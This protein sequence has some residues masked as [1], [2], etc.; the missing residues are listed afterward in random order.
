[1][2]MMMNPWNTNCSLENRML[3][4]SRNQPPGKSNRALLLTAFILAALTLPACHR[5]SKAPT[6]GAKRYPFTGRVISIDAKDQSALINGDNI[7]GFMD[8]MAMS[9]KIKPPSDLDKLAAGDSISAEVVV[10]EEEE[11][12]GTSPDYWLENVKVTA[13]AKAKE[14]SATTQ[15][16]PAPGDVVPD[17]S[18]TNQNGRTVSLKQYH[19]KVLLVTFIYT[20]CPFQDFC[21]RMSSNFAQIYNQL[22]TDKTLGARARLLS[23]SFDPEH[24]KPKVLREYAYSVAH[25]HDPKLFREWGFAT[26]RPSDLP[27]IAD[28]FGVIYKTENGRITHNLSTTVIGPDGKIVSWYHGGDWQPSDLIKDATAAMN[29][30]SSNASSKSS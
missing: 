4:S 3:S 21:P 29:R 27:K 30:Q 13:H 15:R 19:G 11:K 5:S 25:T 16:I 17:F 28:F 23:V 9:Y 22:M 12:T 7:P 10:T 2:M 20:R 14:N 24:D 1:M 6:A 8:A 26:P 18:F